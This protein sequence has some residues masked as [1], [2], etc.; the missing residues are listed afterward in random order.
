ML[1]LMEYRRIADICNKFLINLDDWLK[2]SN[3][4]DINK[5]NWEDSIKKF[6]E[7]IDDSNIIMRKGTYN[8]L[9]NFVI[10][11]YDSIFG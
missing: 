5:C 9:L 4:S 2:F 3:C 10:I 1:V 7:Y 6:S 8:K 11:E